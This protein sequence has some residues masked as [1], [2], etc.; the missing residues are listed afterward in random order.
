M[1]SFFENYIEELL[2][3]SASMVQE[4]PNSQ[5][6]ISTHLSLLYLNKY[7][8]CP[9]SHYSSQG[10]D[11]IGLLENSANMGDPLALFVFGML[12]VEGLGS[13][14]PQNRLIGHTFIAASAFKKCYWALNAMGAFYMQ[15]NGFVAKNFGEARKCFVSALDSMSADKRTLR[16][17]G[18]CCLYIGDYPEAIYYLKRAEL[19]GDNTLVTIYNLQARRLQE[20]QPLIDSDDDAIKQVAYDFERISRLVDFYN[21]AMPE[22]SSIVSVAARNRHNIQLA[23]N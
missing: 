14:F 7:L 21:V 4:N 10:T 8:K 5:D 18:L 23:V 2:T 17:L 11:F 13:I 16:N 22:Q 12:N 20:A 9:A 6:V 19:Q 15:G 1:A 3:Y